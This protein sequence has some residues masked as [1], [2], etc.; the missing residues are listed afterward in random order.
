MAD[1]KVAPK[2]LAWIFIMRWVIS[3]I[4]FLNAYPK[5]F[6]PNFG[7][8]AQEYFLTLRDDIIMHGHNP[9]AKIFH[10]IIIPNAYIFAWL[11]KH[12]EMFISLAF[13]FGFP[14]RMATWAAVLL[15]ANYF[16]IASVP[17][18]MYLNIIM[19]VA[20]FTCLASKEG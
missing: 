16:M 18:L 17:S 2:A 11:V 12:L 15:H 5:F 14:M 1:E 13:F 6:D 4:F 9:Y 3:L 10:T 8:A 19:V 20:E 7:A